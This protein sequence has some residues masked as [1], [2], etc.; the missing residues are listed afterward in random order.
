MRDAAALVC[1]VA[2][3]LG[4]GIGWGARKITGISAVRARHIAVS[5]LTDTLRYA[6]VRVNGTQRFA[7]LEGYEGPVWTVSVTTMAPFKDLQI[8]NC[9]GVVVDART[10]AVFGAQGGAVP[11]LKCDSASNGDAQ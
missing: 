8:A 1:L 9:L 5:W 2:G 3:L 10:G 4:A 7:E 11:W 6:E